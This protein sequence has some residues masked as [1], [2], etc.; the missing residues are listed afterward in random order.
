MINGDRARRL[1]DKRDRFRFG[2]ARRYGVTHQRTRRMLAPFV[3][4]G[5]AE[6]ARCREPIAP[7]E[8]WDL[9][10]DDLNPELHTGPEH[11]HCNRGAP[12]RNQT[13][14]EW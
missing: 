3:A 5:L 6:C 9:G 7:G 1:T 12:H 10:H 14:R 8:P 13:S 2:H 11:A 4:A